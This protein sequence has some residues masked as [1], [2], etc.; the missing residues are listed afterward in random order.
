MRLGAIEINGAFHLAPSTIEPVARAVAEPQT[1]DHWQFSCEGHDV[2]A[3]L[4]GSVERAMQ[5]AFDA[6]SSRGRNRPNHESCVASRRVRL[7][8]TPHGFGDTFYV[9][10]VKPKVPVA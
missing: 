9:Q 1:L 4:I 8:N 7:G 5:G 10:P 6:A 3:D 2:S